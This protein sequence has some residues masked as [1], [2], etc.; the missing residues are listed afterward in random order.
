M[1]YTS[2]N[3]KW[4]ISFKRSRDIKKM[5]KLYHCRDKLV[6]IS[7]RIRKIHSQEKPNWQWQDSLE[8]EILLSSRSNG[9][10]PKEN[11]QYILLTMSL[12]KIKQ[13]KSLD[14]CPVSEKGIIAEMAVNGCIREREL[15][16]YWALTTNKVMK[17]SSWIFLKEKCVPLQVMGHKTQAFRKADFWK[18]SE[19]VANPI[20]SD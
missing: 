1:V 10:L 5:Q 4:T 18:S 16:I 20:A 7:W 12:L 15:N 19:K 6:S 17:A 9:R 14:L 13:G 2:R 8:M 11:A 3:G